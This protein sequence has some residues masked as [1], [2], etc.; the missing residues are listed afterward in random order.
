MRMLESGKRVAFVSP[1]LHGRHHEETW[2]CLKD[3]SWLFTTF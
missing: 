2:S 1:E 3:A